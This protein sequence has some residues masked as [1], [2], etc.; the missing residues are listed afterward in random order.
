MAFSH[1]R[2][3]SKNHAGAATGKRTVEERRLPSTQT[4]VVALSEVRQD[5]L[6]LQAGTAR[7]SARGRRAPYV[8]SSDV[9]PNTLYRAVLATTSVNF[10]L[11]SAAEQDVLLAGY[12]AFLNGLGF[13]VQLL[14]RVLPLDLDPYLERLS[15]VGTR[16]DKGQSGDDMAE[17]HVGGKKAIRLDASLTNLAEDHVAFVRHLAGRHMLLERHFY[18]VI[19]AE[20]ALAPG[21]SDAP[22]STDDPVPS[23]GRQFHRV[24][25]SLLPSARR[26]RREAAARARFDVVAQR[27]DL[28]AGEVM[29]SLARFGV[30]ARRL[31][32]FQLVDLYYSC[33]SPTAAALH[34]LPSAAAA[35]A[36]FPVT[37]VAQPG[38]TEQSR[39]SGAQSPVK[40]TSTSTTTLPAEDEA[41]AAPSAVA[42]EVAAMASSNTEEERQ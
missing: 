41:A 17:Q 12:R 2:R 31:E 23:S 39:Q 10:S 19:P 42:V 5:V 20:S 26:A 34:P 25:P 29:R 33:L 24:L 14:V 21:G 18:I 27:L 35:A 32:G 30:E 15:A 16:E 40:P 38:G 8:S 6:C 36:L 4:R 22:L 37:R 7:T 11:K 9:P 13:P 1:R 3:N 28:R